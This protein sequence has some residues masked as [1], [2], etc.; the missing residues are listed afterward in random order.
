M[1]GEHFLQR[2]SSAIVISLNSKFQ[3]TSTSNSQLI[4][5]RILI[6]L[7]YL[8]SHLL[9]DDAGPTLG[10]GCRDAMRNITHSVPSKS[11]QF[12]TKN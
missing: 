3:L 9:K 2:V 11:L 8:Y 5:L 4:S 10:N 1:T 7:S 6:V 12:H